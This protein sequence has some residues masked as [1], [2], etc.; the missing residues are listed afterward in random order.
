MTRCVRR[1]LIPCTFSSCS[2]LNMCNMFY[3]NASTCHKFYV[4]LIFDD[5]RLTSSPYSKKN[6][7]HGEEFFRFDP[8]KKGE[9]RR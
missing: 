7:F 9:Q 6:Y 8:E 2:A 5:E 3:Y 4:T 1:A